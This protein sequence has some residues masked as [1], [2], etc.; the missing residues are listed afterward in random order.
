MRSWFIVAVLCAVLVSVL[1]A[2]ISRRTQLGGLQNMA[3][4]LGVLASDTTQGSTEFR[5]VSNGKTAEA[6]WCIIDPYSTRCE[7][8]RIQHGDATHVRVAQPLAHVHP[9]GARVL[10]RESPDYSLEL[11][12][13]RVGRGLDP[14]E[15]HTN[16][17]ALVR[18]INSAGAAGGGTVRFPVGDIELEMVLVRGVPTGVQLMGAGSGRTV[19]YFCDPAESSTVEMHNERRIGL[20]LE[21]SPPKRV[22]WLTSTARGGDR[23][24]T[25]HDTGGIQPGDLIRI[26][27]FSCTEEGFGSW[28]YDPR[29]DLNNGEYA[30][31]SDVSPRERSLTLVTAVQ[32]SVPY[33][34]A[35]AKVGEPGARAGSAI[36]PVDSE[37]P[38]ADG[39]RIVVPLT[40]GGVAH[41]VIASTGDR[42]VTVE[43]G[44]PGAC[45]P[46]G[47]ITNLVEVAEANM[48]KGL[49]IRGL[50]IVVSSES[51]DLGGLGLR[52][53][54]DFA[55]EDVHVY[56][57]TWVGI[58]LN[59]CV[60]GSVMDFVVEGGELPG[61][62]TGYGVQ[63][64]GS[65]WVR[66]SDGLVRKQRR[67]IDLSGEHPSRMVTVNDCI[68]EGSGVVDGATVAG[69]H[70]TAEG[71]TFTNNTIVG[72][73]VAGLYIRGN[74]ISVV[75]NT[76]IGT[77]GTAIFLLDGARW[78]VVANTV[79]GHAAQIGSGCQSVPIFVKLHSPHG[80]LLQCAGNVGSVCWHHTWVGDRTTEVELHIADA[81]AFD[82]SVDGER[83]LVHASAGVRVFLWC[84]SVPDVPLWSGEGTIVR[85]AQGDDSG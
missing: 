42:S 63:T 85:L 77:A 41:S 38:W 70:G 28:P 39:T 27:S 6:S 17:T 62:G 36:V 61:S 19:L 14:S 33:V 2:S 84:S 55:I 44:L 48:S 40:E 45:P 79:L 21:G 24:L 82:R 16:A 26:T 71:C 30:Y 13:L 51:D 57:G 29:P 60:N 66:I 11:F 22:T 56:G 7:V 37:S 23:H 75:G 64:Y 4:S 10:F 54:D 65:Q 72:G 50:S 53:F 35:S 31:V 32:S 9:S 20:G 49:R 59:N 68:L 8:L 3:L 47:R 5:Y 18:A 78:L 52:Y 67:A 76:F 46:G 58:W 69:T 43:S 12:G 80:Q 74:D 25:V 81:I 34:V 1:Q 15:W 83:S 73:N